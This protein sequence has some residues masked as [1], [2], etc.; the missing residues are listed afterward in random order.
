[1]KPKFYTVDYG[2]MLSI[3]NEITLHMIYETQIDHTEYPDFECWYID[4]E[5]SGLVRGERGV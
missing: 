4:M 2:D 1:M 3:V 5:R